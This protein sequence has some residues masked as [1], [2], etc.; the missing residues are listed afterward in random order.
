MP[1]SSVQGVAMDTLITGLLL[2]G[3]LGF[4]MAIVL[5]V[6]WVLRRRGVPTRYERPDTIDYDK[7]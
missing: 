4:P 3:V 1:L 2:V 5:F 6:R 7:W